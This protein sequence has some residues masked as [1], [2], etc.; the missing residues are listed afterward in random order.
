MNHASSQP[1]PGWYP[2]PAGSGGER[3]WDGEGWSHVTR[4]SALPFEPPTGTSTYPPAYASWW[5]RVAAHLV[6]GLLLAVPAYLLINAFAP[7]A[8]ETVLAWLEQV[9]LHLQSGRTQLPPEPTEAMEALARG[10]LATHILAVIYHTAFV[11]WRGASL[12]K[13]LL[14]IK[15]VPATEPEAAKPDLLRAFFR[16]LVMEVLSIGFLVFVGFV[17]F[18]L[19]LFTPSK[20]T[21][22]DMVAGTV[23]VKNTNPRSP[24]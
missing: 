14:R 16:A 18:L 5:A 23:V 6:D 8:Y 24:R 21:L 17:S 13:M 4:P 3:Y 1:A 19:P 11:T 7:G 9:M 10:G 12:G 2:D 15:V 20:Q 22:H